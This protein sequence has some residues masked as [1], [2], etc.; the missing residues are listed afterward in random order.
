M[1]KNTHILFLIFVVMAAGPVVVESAFAEVLPPSQFAE[2]AEDVEN[3][4]DAELDALEAEVEER[5][6]ETSEA[7]D[8]VD[9]IEDEFD[10]VDLPS[11]MQSFGYG[12]HAATQTMNP[13]ISLIADFALAWFSDDPDLVGGHDPGDVGFNLQG[14]ELGIQAAIDPY[15]RFD[16]FILF[17]QFGVE[18]EEAY[19]TTLNLP[20]SLQL[21]MGQ[22]LTSFGRINPTHLHAW[23]FVIQPL[24]LGKFFG[25]E[26]L[27]GLGLETSQLLPLPW[28]A[29][30]TLAVQ[31]IGGGATGRSFLSSTAEIESLLD[32]TV[33]GRLEQYWDLADNIGLLFGLS[34]VNGPN[35]T[36]RNNRSDVFGADL[37]L[38]WNPAV[39]GGYRELGWQSE[40]LLRRRQSP[41]PADETDGEVLQDWGGYSEL[42]YSPN[43]LWRFAG[44]YEYVAG[45]DNDPLDPGW[46]EDRQRVSANLTWYPSHFSRLRFE[47]ALD[48]MPYR[49]EGDELVHMAFIQLE[50]VAGAHAAHSY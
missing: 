31:N 32:L 36:G 34:A 8:S 16:S 6:D 11:P 15:F 19:G 18:I 7:D 28:L 27:R 46:N 47:Y 4:I 48:S 35:S 17:S 45:I 5:F 38:K 21:R 14:L 2:D 12:A 40:F 9:E 13:D 25:G 41:G 44:R 37:L 49:S 39:A 10:I 50:L 24:A 1:K 22:F 33:S 42:Y 26:G 3:D 43:L 29:E 23:N 30:W 20:W